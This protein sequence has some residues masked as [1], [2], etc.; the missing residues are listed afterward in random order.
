[1]IESIQSSVQ[2]SASLANS[3][4]MDETWLH[5]LSEG[6]LVVAADWQDI[7]LANAAARKMLT[8][9][10]GSMALP[11]ELKS[12]NNGFACFDISQNHPAQ[13]RRIEARLQPVA[14]H[15]KSA[16]L[17]TLT[18]R[19]PQ[20]DA[21][22]ARRSL[23]TL[24]DNLPGMVYHCMNDENWT[25][26][27]LS[28]RARELTGYSTEDLLRNRRVAYAD[29]I[30]PEDR[31]YVWDTV[32]Q[33]VAQHRPFEMTYRIRTAGG[34]IK[35]VWEH[36]CG[37]FGPEGELLA[38]EGFITDVTERKA[39]EDA[40]RNS[41]LRIR[42][43]MNSVRLAAITLNPQ[44]M[45]GFCNDYFLEITGY[46]RD[47][48]VGRNWFDEFIPADAG[49][50]PRD[51]FLQAMLTGHVPERYEHTV[52]TRGGGTRL[53]AWNNALLRDALGQI[54]AIASIGEDV[55]ERKWVEQAQIAVY[56]I[57]QMTN[58][59][60]RLDELYRKIHQTVS[61]LMPAHN[62]YIALYDPDHDLLSYP[63]FVDEKDSPPSP[64]PPGRGLTAYILRTGQP[65]LATPEIF[66]ILRETHEVESVGSTSLDWLGVPLK[67]ENHIIGAMVIQ[68]YEG[69]T[70]YT[71]RHMQI[72][73][74]MSDQVASVIERKRAEEALR[75]SQATNRAVIESSTDAILLETLDGH[76]LDCNSAA[77]S[78]Y[79][80]PREELVGMHISRLVPPQRLERILIANQQMVPE[81]SMVR[82]SMGVRSDGSR[83][84]S[85]VSTRLTRIRGEEC[86][87]TFVRDIT[88]RK[89]DE[90]A[91]LASEAK[92]R[93]LAQSSTTGIFIHR[94]GNYLYVNPMWEKL[95][96]YSEA[97]LKQ[98][99]YL[100]LL[101]PEERPH[102]ERRIKARL[103]N[104]PV[105]GRV[106]VKIIERSGRERWLE[107][108]TGLLE[109]EGLPT[110]VGT[111]IDITDRKLYERE[112]E[113][114]GQVSAA[115]RTAMTRPQILSGILE[116][117]SNLLSPG[118][119][120]AILRNP[121]SGELVVEQVVEESSQLAGRVL[122]PG[123]G[124][125]L[126]VIETGQVYFNNN[127]HNDPLFA[128]PEL[129]DR[130][131]AL[132]GIP[133]TIEGH[134]IGALVVGLLRPFMDEEIRLLTAIGD[135]ISSALHRAQLYDRTLQ[136]ATELSLAY[137]ETIE[138]WARAL[139]LRDKETQGHTR[140]VATL[141]LLLA[142][143]M[144]IPSEQYVNIRRGALLHDIGK[145]GISDSILLKPGPLSDEEREI[146]CRHPRMAYELLADI[147]Y[148]RDS[149]DIPY[150]H[151]E[152]WD[153][154]GYPRRLSGEE[155]PLAARIF[156]VVDVWDA[157]TSD[158]PYRP[159]WTREAA[160]EYIRNESGRHFDPAVVTHF[161]EL[162]RRGEV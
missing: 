74:F 143:S 81:K 80:Y 7:F 55:T 117:V 52:R 121:S 101:T 118:V 120:A 2:P 128:F 144:G 77:C 1:M 40:Q 87:V 6:V 155:I 76:V 137:E 73:R 93:G 133:I 146:M 42:E 23:Q 57:S 36:G 62:F 3:F 17:V 16:Y 88:E 14:W 5:A 31:A 91:L 54:S 58:T 59:A 84:P 125:S 111:A 10:D 90:A 39:V 83:F 44:G 24:K 64:E 110:V 67:I 56:R 115:V 37:R 78:L 134:T 41:E 130:I 156:A 150:A 35:W 49:V 11:E 141:T 140:R 154:H 127:A 53:I 61:E 75:S 21:E 8:G 95:T 124:V 69:G 86:L 135:I 100:D 109:Y 119:A 126:H 26:T 96:G 160:K 9:D 92:F 48:V 159:A 108:G 29:L 65:L 112:L 15:G 116:Q 113:V 71:H 139:E 50:A 33:G 103:R 32:Q 27:D 98:M 51:I 105:E 136:H 148:L 129:L 147:A 72:M 114:V 132:V 122:P 38:L 97:E 19:T 161:L 79:G 138:G 4:P 99:S 68:S 43:W 60:T 12:H 25:M 142:E 47:E 70:R 34:Q 18:D 162:F 102:A 104:E 63:Y 152:R 30:L 82:E 28:G 157:L 89:N 151:H 107:V 22:E 94:G 158:R 153:G 145:M 131:Q 85:E 106:E 46:H 149:L 13:P 20:I 66:E 123:R 45:V